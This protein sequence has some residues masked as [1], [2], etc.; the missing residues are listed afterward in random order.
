[1]S[2]G[3]GDHRSTLVTFAV[4][5]VGLAVLWASFSEKFDALHVG[6]GVFSVGLT[7]WMSRSLLHAPDQPWRGDWATHVRWRRV[8]LYPVWL[9]WEIIKANVDV[10]KLI[11][12]PEERIDPVLLRFETTLEGALATVALGNSITLTPGTFTL[13][14]EGRT[15]RVHALTEDSATSPVIGQMERLLA[16]ALGTP[17]TLA[18]APPVVT[19][20]VDDPRF[21]GGREE[22]A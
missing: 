16:E 14:I 13:E 1:M 20:D 11:L 6:F 9:Q 5:A 4:A 18:D 2:V 10:A 8:L 21:S 3:T 19:R 15:L 22:R 17:V 12:G 7:L